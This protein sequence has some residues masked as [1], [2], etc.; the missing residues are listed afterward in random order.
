MPTLKFQNFVVL[1]NHNRISYGQAAYVPIYIWE[2]RRILMVGLRNNFSRCSYAVYLDR[3]K[4][5]IPNSRLLFDVRGT[6]TS[7]NEHT[8]QSDME[9]AAYNYTLSYGTC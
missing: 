3:V 5:I 9:N 7:G 1:R 4:I 8:S 6:G 2:N